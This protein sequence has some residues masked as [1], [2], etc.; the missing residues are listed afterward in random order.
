MAVTRVYI[1]AKELGV[2][3]TA[4]VKKCQD[5]GLDVKN[6]MSAISAGLAATIRE[7]FSEGEN[8]TTVEVAKKVDLKKARIKKKPRRKRPAKEAKE[9]KVVK[10]KSSVESPQVVAE[11]SAVT[12]AEEGEQ[13]TAVKKMPAR[14]K[15]PPTPEVTEVTTDKLQQVRGKIVEEP[16][17]KEPEPILPAGPILEK[18]EPAQLSGPK[19]VRVE[20]PE[21][22]RRPRPRPRARY[23]IPVTEPLMYNEDETGTLASMP[24]KEE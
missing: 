1:L 6:H 17:K 20:A 23:D 16:K 8:I 4:I 18:P 2:K 13:E 21:P 5:E 24:K 7:W 11:P 3:S 19:V 12:E 14:A 22:L 9:P 15:E 10:A